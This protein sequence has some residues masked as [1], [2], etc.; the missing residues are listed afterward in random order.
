MMSRSHKTLDGY[1]ADQAA[2]KPRPVCHVTEMRR[3]N[4]RHTYV[5]DIP[6]LGH[7]PQRIL[8]GEVGKMTLAEAEERAFAIQDEL[9]QAALETG[10]LVD[11]S[12][13]ITFAQ[14]INDH[15][16]PFI[17]R[18]QRST[19]STE[20][21]LRNWILPSLGEL[22]INDITDRHILFLLRSLE[23][24]GL[25]PG[26]VNRILN[27]VK[28]CFSK[29]LEWHL[30]HQGVS[31]AAGISERKII[32]KTDR[33]L[34]QAEARRLTEEVRH[35]RNPLLFPIVGF[36]LM[37]GARRSEALR[38]KWD[39]IDLKK[40]NWV[41]PISKS[42]RP[43]HIPLSL[44]AIEFLNIAKK[45]SRRFT[46]AKASPYVFPNLQTGQPFKNL[47]N[48]WDTARSRA[49]LKDVRPHDLRHSFASALVNNGHS[50]Y[51]VKELLGHSSVATTQRYAHLS[52][53][54][55]DQATK[56]VSN[57][58]NINEKVH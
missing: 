18:S 38:A 6:G 58:Y 42:G 33:F 25:K 19:G 1:K 9:R 5:T 48:S 20:S 51:D 55:L 36:L 8:L 22:L 56:A 44:K 35:S 54:R 12:E 7:A 16:L 47:F 34:S 40:K 11:T 39:H 32:D 49:G 2:A 37:T 15:Y 21:Y 52:R 10:L 46:A 17:A 13:P 53:Q 30:F 31:P 24:S 45:I 27:I 23:I 41:V 28:S 14:F 29:A 26:S 57:Y 4:G 50:I 43:R 3:P